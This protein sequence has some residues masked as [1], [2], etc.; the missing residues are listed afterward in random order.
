MDNHKV[1][2]YIYSLY[3]VNYSFT[4]IIYFYIPELLYPYFMIYEKVKK[5]IMEYSKSNK[6]IKIYFLNK[7]FTF[8]LN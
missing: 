4:Y 1:N 2:I 5:T 6:I 3:Y 7:V 8:I